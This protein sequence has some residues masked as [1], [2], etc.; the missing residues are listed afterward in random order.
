MHVRTDMKEVLDSCRV[1]EEADPGQRGGNER[2]TFSL[3]EAES[4]QLSLAGD[5]VLRK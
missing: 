1:G 3:L 4:R 2:A 5:S